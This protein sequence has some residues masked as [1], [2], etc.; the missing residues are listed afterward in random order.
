MSEAIA[1]LARTFSFMTPATQKVLGQLQDDGQW[2]YRLGEGSHIY[3]LLGHV[4]C[5]RAT[6]L[7][8]L[9]EEYQ[10]AQGWRE[11]FWMGTEPSKEFI[12]PKE[13]LLA[14]FELLGT[15]VHAAMEKVTPEQLAAP[16]GRTFPNGADT[17]GGALQFLTFHEG[18][19]LGQISTTS[20]AQGNP[21]LA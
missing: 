15:K 6:M 12:V 13:E 20:R 11:H 10:K 17:V 7:Q 9:G 16:A 1:E 5:A 21:G 19:H 18:Y 8:L 14:A 3:W 2:L 4:V